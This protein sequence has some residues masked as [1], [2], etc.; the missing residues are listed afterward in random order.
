MKYR[1]IKKIFKSKIIHSLEKLQLNKSDIVIFRYIKG[2]HTF[3]D[4]DCTFQM[5]KRIVNGKNKIIGLPTDISLGSM[6][7]KELFE[8]RS[9][10][11]RLIYNN[12]QDSTGITDR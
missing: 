3:H 12:H 5:I 2:E 10:I 1:K 9:Y 7:T 8:L 11:D 6:S 4:L